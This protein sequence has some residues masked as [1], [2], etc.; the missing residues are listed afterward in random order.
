MTSSQPLHQ[1]AGA[2]N[3]N[4]R[5]QKREVSHDTLLRYLLRT[6]IAAS[7]INSNLDPKQKAIHYISRARLEDE[8]PYV[9]VCKAIRSADVECLKQLAQELNVYKLGA[10]ITEQDRVDG[11]NPIHLAVLANNHQML[12]LLITSAPKINVYNALRQRT[13]SCQCTPL[14]IS[15]ATKNVENVV[16]IVQQLSAGEA[17]GYNPEGVS[18]IKKS[19]IIFK[20]LAEEKTSLL[21]AIV[22]QGTLTEHIKEAMQRLPNTYEFTASQIQILEPF[23]TR[24]LIPVGGPTKAHALVCY[25]PIDREGALAEATQLTEALNALGFVTEMIEWTLFG[26]LRSDVEGRVDNAA[27]HCSM[28]FVAVMSHGIQGQLVSQNGSHGEINEILNQVTN[29]LRLKNR[30]HIPLVSLFVFYFTKFAFNSCQ[31]KLYICFLYS[32]QIHLVD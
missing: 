29:G 21:R 19:D 1:F 16:F 17:F 9:K 7:L 24:Y 22:E 25:N 8:R 6:S 28:L 4:N 23:G 12:T 18:P 26:D 20:L 13:F 27:E 10:I 3:Y 14:G 11:H 32:M 5:L 15:I 31:S 30:E 2:R